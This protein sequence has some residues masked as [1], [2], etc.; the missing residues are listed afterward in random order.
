MSFQWRI[1]NP[2]ISLASS[3]LVNSQVSD[4]SPPKTSRLYSLG[5]TVSGPA[6]RAAKNPSSAST[7]IALPPLQLLRKSPRRS[8]LA[9]VS[10]SFW[11]K[12]FMAN[13]PH[14]AAFV[15]ASILRGISLPQVEDT[16]RPVAPHQGRAQLV[17]DAILPE[18]HRTMTTAEKRNADRLLARSAPRRDWYL[19]NCA[20][21]GGLFLR[22][23][24]FSAT[25][26]WISG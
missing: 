9:S 22:T 16:P 18:Q 1:I 20:T 24:D 8:S 21:R 23:T 13:H 19:P 14:E 7:F 10:G 3:R 26:G 12:V 2:R 4:I 15:S 6:M 25:T 5:I 11:V 17:S